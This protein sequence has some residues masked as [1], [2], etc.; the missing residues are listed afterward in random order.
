MCNTKSLQQVVFNRLAAAEEAHRART[1]AETAG[2]K[3]KRPLGGIGGGTSTNLTPSGGAKVSGEAAGPSSLF[4]LSDRNILRRTTRFLIEW[5]PFEYTVLLT[6]IA[7]CVV[8]ALE[9]HLPNGDRT[10]MAQQLESTEPYFLG[11]FTVEAALK[12]LALGFVLHRGS[13][14]RNAWNIMDFIVVVTG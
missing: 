3:M 5:P 1:K 14:L 7:N 13:Y 6:I 12:I 10:P 8:L 4:I 2:I 11:I 9:E